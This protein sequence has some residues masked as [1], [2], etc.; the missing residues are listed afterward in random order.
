MNMQQYENCSAE[1]YKCAF[2]LLSAS[3]CILCNSI[4]CSLKGGQIFKVQHFNK[5]LLRWS[6]VYFTRT[7]SKNNWTNIRIPVTPIPVSSTSVT[8]PATSI[9]CH[10]NTFTDLQTG[11]KVFLNIFFFFLFL[12]IQTLMA[13]SNS[14]GWVTNEQEALMH[15]EKQ[16]YSEK[17]LSHCQ[18]TTTNLI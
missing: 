13:N 3:R 4:Y 5:Q 15:K 18:L 11:H 14:S 7:C 9:V 10:L 1:K 8:S 2:S 12:A 16:T 6:N 17:N